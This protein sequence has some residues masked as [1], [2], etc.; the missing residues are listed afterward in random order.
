MITG[1][2]LESLPT[3]DGWESCCSFDMLATCGGLP[4]VVKEGNSDG[5]CV[6]PLKYFSSVTESPDGHVLFTHYLSLNI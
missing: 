4:S 3:M 1:E 2:E 5:V 6:G